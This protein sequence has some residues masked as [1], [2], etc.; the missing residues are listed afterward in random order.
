MMPGL[1]S[2]ADDAMGDVARAFGRAARQHQHVAGR[3]RLAHRGFELRLVIG[4]GAEKCASPP[5]SADRRRDDRAVGV[6]D[7]GRAQRL[8]GLHQFIA[9]GDDGD[10]RPARDAH[11]RDAAGRQHADLARADDGASAQQRLAAGDI[12]TGIG[13]ELSGRSGAADVDRA[14]ALPAGCVRPSRRRRHRAAPDRRS[15]STWPFPTRPAASARCRRRSSRRSASA[16]PATPRRQ[17]RDR[18]NAPQSRRHWSGRTAARRSAP[19]RP[20]PARSR[21]RRRAGAFRSD[22][23]RKQRG[24]ETR[25]RILAR[26]DGQELVLIGAITNLFGRGRMWSFWNSYQSRNI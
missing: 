18:R 21:A 11:L 13:D 20:R 3:Q 15:R 9:G 25:Q 8:A 5:F 6:V 16:A 19:P 24:L 10:A 23:A 7:R 1:P 17:R 4:D 14:M 22:R 12:G 2:R 26:Q